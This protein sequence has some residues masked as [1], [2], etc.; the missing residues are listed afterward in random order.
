MPRPRH[1]SN[2]RKNASRR[3]QPAYSRQPG[4]LIVGQDITIKNQ[5]L[6]KSVSILFTSL[7]MA[8]VRPALEPPSCEALKTDHRI[9][10]R[11]PAYP[12]ENAL[13]S[14]A[15]FD[16]ENNDG[17]DYNVACWACGIVANN[18]WASG[19]LATKQGD[20]YQR[21]NKPENGILSQREYYY[22]TGDHPASCEYFLFL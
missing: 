2:R 13:L 9:E 21:V 15:A 10:F 19:W 20:E 11:H 14:L 16:G 18:S 22:F 7:P 8:R 1:S 17:I 12:T 4:Q 5:P 3:S 6:T